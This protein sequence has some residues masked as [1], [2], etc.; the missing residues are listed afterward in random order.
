MARFVQVGG[1]TTG[2]PGVRQDYVRAEGGGVPGF[3]ESG[4]VALIGECEGIMQP[5]VVHTYRSSAKLKGELAK[6]RLYDGC[7]FAL[8]P[9]RD[10]PLD[11][12]G[13]Q[14]IL[15]IRVNPATQGTLTLQSV[16]PANMLTLTSRYYGAVAAGIAATVAAGTLTGPSKKLTISQFGETDE[17]GD[18]LGYNS[19][20]L[21]RYTG[22]A[23]TAVATFNRTAFST[24]LAGDQTD[25]SADLSVAYTAYDT[26]DKLV[27]YINAQTG[28]EAIA[29]TPKPASYKCEDL[30][31]VTNADIK[32]VDSGSVTLAA[33]T[34]TSMT[35]AAVTT[36]N[37]VR[38]DN[39]EYVYI[40]TAGSPNTVIRG[41]NDSTATSHTGVD[42]DEFYNVTGVNKAIIDWCN[43]LSQRVTAVR[44]TDYAVGV[45]NTLS[46]TYLTGAGEGT[47]TSTQ[48]AS[49]FEALREQ[50]VN[51]I[52]PLTDDA[53][54][55][56]QLATH[57]TWRWGKGGSEAIAHV[58][59]AQDETIAQLKSR[60][61]ALNNANICLHFQDLNRDDDAGVDTNYAPWAMAVHAA[62]IQAGTAFGTPLTHKSLNVTAIG[63][64]TAIDLIDDADTFIEFG[65]CHA[66]YYDSE[67]RIVRALTTWTNDDTD[68]K[69]ECNVR[70]STAWTL[71]KVRD[72]LRFYHHGKAAKS[73]NSNAVKGTMKTVLEEIRD[74][75]EAIVEGNRLVNGQIESIPAFKILS[76]SQTGNVA[77]ASYQFVPTGG[78]DFINVGSV[79][80]VFQDA[81]V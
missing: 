26:V 29:I 74:I 7:R 14:K 17:V 45:P 64:N 6:G 57:L 78:T 46:K 13:A 38:L 75:D 70:H 61:K 5:G 53:A 50:R 19:V 68:F 40:T 4:V 43:N 81:A 71:Y 59:A 63:Q 21:L 23:T 11:V 76:V 31:F 62:A 22:D 77:D 79:V 66:R 36:G 58:G 27:N 47:T 73:G 9:S 3:L 49:A 67:Y 60:S 15:A 28:Y 54:V 32:L 56:T 51:F 37:V 2:V 18:S 16:A 55:H 34:T 20:I 65:I 80:G 42:A 12:S 48:W 69:I 24:T 25:G 30:D 35:L 72:R 8:S 1:T 41:Y 33:S 10:D 39:A 44:H 52:V